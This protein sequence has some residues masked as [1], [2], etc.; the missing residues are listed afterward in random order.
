MDAV[1]AD[2]QNRLRWSR[3]GHVLA[4]DIA[5]GLVHLHANQ[6]ILHMLY[7]QFCCTAVA[8]VTQQLNSLSRL[9]GIS[10]LLA[11]HRMLPSSH[12]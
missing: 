2:K 5:K 9:K 8:G 6:V 7:K 10:W 12:H 11:F 3:K 4:M 1:A